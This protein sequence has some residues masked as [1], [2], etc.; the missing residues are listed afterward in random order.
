MQTPIKALTATALF[1]LVSGC[2]GDYRF[3]SNLD[4][5]AIDDY[6]KASDVVV[7]EGNLQPTGPFEILGL[8]EGEA[9]QAEANDK[10]AAI[11]DARTQARRGA[12]DKGAT[13]VIIKQCMQF[14]EAAQGCI[15]RALCVGQAIKQAQPKPKA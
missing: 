11:S 10:P 6:F 12:A 13:G 2:A 7:F 5:E 4:S 8:V 3:T 15:S 9:C 1:C 14:E